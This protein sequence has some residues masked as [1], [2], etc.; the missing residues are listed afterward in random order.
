MQTKHMETKIGILTIEQKQAL[1]NWFAE[2]MENAEQLGGKNPAEWV[3]PNK[4]VQQICEQFKYSAYDMW[5]SKEGQQRPKSIYYSPF[6]DVA[7]SI[8]DYEGRCIYAAY[9]TGKY[10][11]SN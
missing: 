6:E 5:R 1:K 3:I 8:E 4:E 9:M 10:M 2:P 7:R 11:E